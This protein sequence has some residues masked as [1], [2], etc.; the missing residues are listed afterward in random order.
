[1]A[2]RSRQ[3]ALSH[4][5][6][7]EVGFDAARQRI[8]RQLRGELRQRSEVVGPTQARRASEPVA[9]TRRVFV[10]V[11]GTH[12][13]RGEQRVE[14]IEHLARA[15]V[16]PRRRRELAQYGQRVVD[17]TGGGQRPHARQR[18]RP[19]LRSRRRRLGQRLQAVGRQ[20]QRGIDFVV[21]QRHPRAFHQILGQAHRLARTQVGLHFVEQR[22]DARLIAIGDGKEQ[23]GVGDVEG[24]LRQIVL[25]RQCA[26]AREGIARALRVA[27]IAL[28]QIEA[29]ITAARVKERAPR[30]PRERGVTDRLRQTPIDRHHQR[31]EALDAVVRLDEV[32]QHTRRQ[33]QLLERNGRVRR[34]H[35]VQRPRQPLL[36]FLGVEPPGFT[37]ERRRDHRTI[38]AHPRPARR[39]LRLVYQLLAKPRQPLGQRVEARPARMQGG[40]RAGGGE[41]GT[42]SRCLLQ[43]REGRVERPQPGLLVVHRQPQRRIQLRGLLAQWYDSRQVHFFWAS[44]VWSRLPIFRPT[45]VRLRSGGSPRS[46]AINAARSHLADRRHR[47]FHGP[48]P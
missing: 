33:Q 2:R 12:A 19:A 41:Q 23:L 42:R 29:Q 38:D 5:A 7:Q 11:A 37:Q 18:L 1:M 28:L 40:H 9:Q 20:S 43:S 13:Q 25:L 31:L 32:E 48:R 21:Q 16:L 39:Q 6:A 47:N 4:D 44:G 8:G 24:E 34:D 46:A 45:R 36:D 14:A 35:F 27:A 10:L 3:L 22:L 17:A 30:Q 15:R 26:S